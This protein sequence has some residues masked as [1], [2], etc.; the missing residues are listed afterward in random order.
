MTTYKITVT[1][2]T[3]LHR[4]GEVTRSCLYVQ[5]NCGNIITNLIGQ[6]TCRSR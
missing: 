4:V 3:L 5:F 6:R 2:W 1:T